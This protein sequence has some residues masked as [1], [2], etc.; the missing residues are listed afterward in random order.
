MNIDP[1]N[2]TL[3]INEQIKLFKGMN[4][5]ELLIS[6]GIFEIWTEHQNIPASYRSIFKNPGNK[7][8]EIILIVYI[9]LTTDSIQGW[10]L[11]PTKGA[12]GFQK[13]PEGKYT[14]NMRNWFFKNF[15]ENL[16]LSGN[17]GFVDASHDPHNQTTSIICNYQ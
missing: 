11:G 6:S 2:G 9:D 4:K 13:Q 15:S 5:L 8:E 17:W 3:T 14:K 12:N 1:K 7:T 16:P 10:D